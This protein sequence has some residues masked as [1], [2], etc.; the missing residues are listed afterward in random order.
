MI[1][2]IG[3]LF[4][5]ETNFFTAL[6]SHFRDALLINEH[7]N[8]SHIIGGNHRLIDQLIQ[9]LNINY[10]TSVLSIDQ[11]VDQT[12]K[13]T[14]NN[15][16]QGETKEMNFDR[17]IVATSAPAARLIRYSPRNNQMKSMSRALRQ[18]HYDCS[19]KIVLY[20]NRSWWNDQQ[21]FGGSTITDLPLRFIYYDNYNTTI[22]QQNQT[23]FVLL[24]SYSFAQ[25]STL[26]SSSTLDQITG[27]ALNNLEEIHS[28]NDLR[29]FYLR[30][31]VKHWCDDP[32]SH[33]AYALYLP[34]QEEDLQ[35]I[36][37]Q[38]LNGTLFFAGEHLSTAHAW[39]EGSI[40]S[41]LKVLMRM[42]DEQFHFVIVGG[43]LLA[44]QTA[45]Q[46]TDRQNDFNILMI[47]RN[48][49]LDSFCS[50]EFEPI[51]SPENQ[52]GNDYLQFGRNS[53][54]NQFNTTEM[55]GQLLNKIHREKFRRITLGEN[56]RF[57]DLIGNDLFTDRRR[58]IVKRKVLFLDNCYL[59]EYLQRSFHLNIHFEEYP[60]LTFSTKGNLS[61]PIWS[62]ENQLFAFDLHN[63]KEFQRKM[64]V[65][66]S[67]ITLGLS[68]LKRHASSLVELNSMRNPLIYKQTKL[69]EQE[70]II[71]YLP[72]SNNQSIV[73]FSRTNFD[74]N[75]HWVN[76]LSDL[77]F[78]IRSSSMNNYSI[79]ISNDCFPLT[80]SIYL[81]FVCFFVFISKINS[82]NLIIDK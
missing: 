70:S 22:D 31:V 66:N 55:I 37:S 79:S 13:I 7:T 6:T 77:S 21:I 20:F 76:L 54:F 82:S 25:D 58:L 64:I 42:Q 56:E 9:S 65:F 41:S 18:L 1:D 5:I 35:P 69:I 47:E 60:L 8:F 81:L 61:L 38:S 68:W 43:G 39:F 26:W 80:S 78:D 32:Y 74:R 51:S 29:N 12:I 36:L 33:G 48:S 34:D 40:L 45:I 57:I 17:V 52:T 44:L 28:R 49:F 59:N 16:L 67:N 2:Y 19:S 72:N 73:Y 71:D 15:H 46:L 50:N 24:A 62:Y 30:T 63:R 4:G 14:F 11:N 23:E 53:S 27:E 75:S 10:S 3:L